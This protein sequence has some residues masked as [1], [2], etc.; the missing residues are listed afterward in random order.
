[1]AEEIPLVDGLCGCQSC[2]DGRLIARLS[3]A[4][5]A[6]RQDL[7]IANE[8]VIVLRNSLPKEPA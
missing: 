7:A 3:D 1:M 4:V 8:T 5:A 2:K 6:L